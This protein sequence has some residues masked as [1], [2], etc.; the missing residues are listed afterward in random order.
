MFTGWVATACD[1]GE[2]FDELDLSNK[3][4]SDYDEKK[5]RQF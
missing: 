1:S 3:E 4:W 5:V 2:V